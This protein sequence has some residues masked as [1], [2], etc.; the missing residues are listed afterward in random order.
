V[1]RAEDMVEFSAF[2][3]FYNEKTLKGTYYGSANIHRDFP[4]LLSLWRAGKLDLEGMITRRLTIDD[5]N[6]AFG[7]LSSGDV[8]RQV[9]T[10]D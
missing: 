3:L 8:I 1:G 9:I 4:R 5:V 10:F 6:D 7:A 2:D